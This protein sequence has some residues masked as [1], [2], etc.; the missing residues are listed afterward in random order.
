MGSANVELV[1]SIFAAWERGN[2]SPVEWAHPEV[3]YVIADGPTPGTWSG[4]AAMAEAAGDFL[5]V[6]EEL[7]TVAT[8]YSELD[9][10]R[11]LVLTHRGG[12]REVSE[13]DL[14]QVEA[15]GAHLFRVCDG[16][17]TKIVAYNSRQ[18][19]L[20]DLGLAS[21]LGRRRRRTDRLIAPAIVV[22]ETLLCLTLWGPQPAAW[23]W[24]GSQVNHQTDSL[25]A[26]LLVAFFGAVLTMV[27]T[28]TLAARLD[29]IWRLVRSPGG[30]EQ[31][32]GVLSAILVASAAIA[33]P[34]FLFWLL[35]I[36]GP[37]D[38][39]GIF[40]MGIQTSLTGMPDLN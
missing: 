34:C 30:F 2:Y 16:K 8:D 40:P 27:G 7:R 26:G 28:I 29:R 39:P 20:A 6:W 25:M 5:S 14:G 15:K 32:E 10:E 17:V 35:V 23:L 11:V 3:E 22:M 33:V 38:A 19:A 4:L 9:D 31:Q 37:G 12:R 1:R 24:V 36:E 21:Q 13:L 18:R